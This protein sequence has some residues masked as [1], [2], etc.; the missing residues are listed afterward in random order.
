MWHV[1]ICKG[2]QQWLEEFRRPTQRFSYTYLVRSI[3]APT[4]EVP[5]IPKIIGNRLVDSSLRSV[6]FHYPGRRTEQILEP[7]WCNGHGHRP[8]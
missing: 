8:D 5:T 2:I 1:F 4:E 6:I 3:I 7:T